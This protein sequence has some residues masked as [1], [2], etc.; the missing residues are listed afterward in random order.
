[1]QEIQTLAEKFAACKKILRALSKCGARA[2][3]SIL[4]L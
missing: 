3:K 2:P 4:V 1:M